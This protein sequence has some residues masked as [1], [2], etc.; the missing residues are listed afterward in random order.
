MSNRQGPVSR[1]RSRSNERTRNNQN[2]RI[3]SD[4]N[5]NIHQ[6]ENEYHNV[7]GR[8]PN[9]S[10]RNRDFQVVKSD[11][12]ISKNE[13]ARI[14]QLIEDEKIDD[15]KSAEFIRGKFGT[16]CALVITK[17]WKYVLR[18]AIM[19]ER[20]EPNKLCIVKIDEVR[21]SERIT[22]CA[23]RLKLKIQKGDP[24]HLDDNLK[25]YC[26]IMTRYKAIS[27]LDEA[28]KNPGN[29]DIRVGDYIRVK[30]KMLGIELYWHAGIYIG[31]GKV[32][33]FSAPPGSVTVASARED[34]W[35]TFLSDNCV[36][37]QVVYHLIPFKTVEEI[38]GLSE[39][40]V[41]QN[42]GMGQ[43]DLVL[44]NCEHLCSYCTTGIWESHQVTRVTRATAVG[45][46]VGAGLLLGVIVTTVA[47]VVLGNG[48][49]ELE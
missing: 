40:L 37:L 10:N 19:D 47:A 16:K 4:S 24:A 3:R 14:I 33:H 48:Q 45:A 20:A 41:S 7:N 9:I 12:G 5:D 34:D 25:G 1:S 26:E 17:C 23:E 42:Y 27:N 2:Y 31:N 46:G 49:Q 38:L 22:T 32:R 18:L 29:A 30:R 11:A 21:T 35:Q 43:Y 36:Q 44:N 8:I 15:I 13:R 6:I 28:M 39:K